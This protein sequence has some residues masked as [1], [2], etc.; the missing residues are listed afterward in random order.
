L[1]SILIGLVFLV[2]LSVTVLS[3]RPG[4][5]RRQLRFAARRLRITLVL[6]GIFVMCSLIIRLAFP[7]GAVADYGPPALAVVLAAAFLVLA[8]DPVMPDPESR[9]H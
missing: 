2:G 1:R 3:L 8:R 6:G 7:D 9:V 4:G 5:L